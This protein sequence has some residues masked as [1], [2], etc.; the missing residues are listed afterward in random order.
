MSTFEKKDAARGSQVALSRINFR[1]GAPSNRTSPD[2]A[3]KRLNRG[4]IGLR[5][6]LQ[7]YLGSYRQFSWCAR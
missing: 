2:A 3:A 1:S 6:G 7:F 5:D 4:P